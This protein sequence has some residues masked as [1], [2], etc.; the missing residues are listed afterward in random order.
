MTLE[1]LRGLLDAQTEEL[2]RTREKSGNLSDEFCRQQQE[3]DK[4]R[5][6][7]FEAQ[8]LLRAWGRFDAAGL[9]G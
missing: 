7:L 2:A 6:R 5:D 8:S 4:T 9:L 3:A 1:Q